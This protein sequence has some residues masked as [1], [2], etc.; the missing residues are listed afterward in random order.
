MKLNLPKLFATTFALW[1]FTLFVNF[2][3]SNYLFSWMYSLP[4]TEIWLPSGE[5][6]L[7]LNMFGSGLITLLRSLIFVLVYVWIYKALP[8]KS[9][10][11]GANYGF[12]VWFIGAFTGYAAMPFYLNINYFVIIYWI[13]Q[14]LV[15]NLFL[16]LFTAALYKVKK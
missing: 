12:I 8:G 15:L 1:L 5:S 7:S 10:T 16:G 9:L 3:T 11:K 6:L 2:I 4:P 13:V 14:A